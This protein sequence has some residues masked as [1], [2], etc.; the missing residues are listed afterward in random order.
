[1][2]LSPGQQ[3]AAPNLSP[4]RIAKALLLF[5]LIA[6]PFW[7]YRENIREYR[8]YLSEDRPSI[9][10]H[11][12]E[13][14]EQWTEADLRR[15][16]V[17]FK[18]TCDRSFDRHLDERACF[19]DVQEY[20]QVPAMFVAFFFSNGRLSRASVNVPWWAHESAYKLLEFTYGKPSHSQST[21]SAGVRLHGWRLKEDAAVFYNRDKPINPLEWNAIFWNSGASCR[22]N[23]CFAAQ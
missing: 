2:Q 8:L 4:A 6:T 7:L 19:I 9:Q 13:L 18:I 14:S 17:A 21:P 16:F 10:F 22:K 20:N 23:G 5:A 1:M 15:R 11:F 3:P 12:S